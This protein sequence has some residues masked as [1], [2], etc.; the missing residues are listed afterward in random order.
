MI[1]GTLPI[2]N[3]SYQMAT[4]KL[5]ELKVQ[6]VGLLEH[7]SI[8]RNTSL[9]RAPVLF[10]KKKDNSLSLCVDY[11]QLNKVTIKNRFLLPTIDDLFDE[12]K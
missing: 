10:V 9:W 7:S 12:L 6:I 11:L 4:A 3:S 2:S 1:P 8:R 5:K